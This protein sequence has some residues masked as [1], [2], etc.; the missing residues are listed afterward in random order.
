MAATLADR[1]L[2]RDD[3]LLVPLRGLGAPWDRVHLATS[4]TPAQG[5]SV[6]KLLVRPPQA[7][8]QRPHG[9]KRL[10]EALLFATAGPSLAA[11][12]TCGVT[13]SCRAEDI[14]VSL[15]RELRVERIEIGHGVVGTVH[16]TEVDVPAVASLLAPMLGVQ[17]DTAVEELLV[18]FGA[19]M[20]DEDS[21][22]NLFRDRLRL[23]RHAIV[24]AT[25]GGGV[26]IDDALQH[27]GIL[28]RRRSSTRA[29]VLAS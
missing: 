9:T 22:R 10:A 12:V 15:D 3:D 27:V 21:V 28:A 13:L 7:C 14:G 17:L 6:R 29:V 20:G 2:A 16:G 5:Q 11:L 4:A 8:A 26:A 24:R 23:L 25:G 19:L 18:S 1:L